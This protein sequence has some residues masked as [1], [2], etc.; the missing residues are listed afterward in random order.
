[1]RAENEKMRQTM[2]RLVGMTELIMNRV[3]ENRNDTV[4]SNSPLAGPSEMPASVI[5]KALKS[6]VPKTPKP[7]LIQ[8]N[9]EF[10]DSEKIRAYFK[11]LVDVHPGVKDKSDEIK[12]QTIDSLIKNIRP[13]ALNS[14][15]KLLRDMKTI[16]VTEEGLYWQKVPED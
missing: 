9:K 8:G 16:T 13:I 3:N 11:E 14:A 7:L 1:M 2:D 5:P 15:K 4:R 6:V 12:L 10:G